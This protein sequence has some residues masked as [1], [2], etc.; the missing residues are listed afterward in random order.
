MIGALMARARATKSRIPRIAVERLGLPPSWL[1]Y[2][3][4]QRETLAECAART[5]LDDRLHVVHPAGVHPAPLP[6]DVARRDA[7]PDDRGW[8]G[9]SFRDVPARENDPTLIATLPDCTIAHDRLPP[10]HRFGGDYYVGILNADQRSLELREIRFRPMHAEVLNAGPRV[11]RIDRATLVTERVYHNYSHWLTAHLPKLVLLRERGE[12]NNVILPP[13]LPENHRAS[14]RMLGIEPDDFRVFDPAAVQ[15][16]R[17]LT[18]L[19]TD[20]F[21]PELVRSVR[22]RIM[23]ATSTA[24]ATPTASPT[25]TAGATGTAASSPTA[26]V[27]P[28]AATPRRRIYISRAGALRRR[29][30]NEED[31]WPSFAA[32]GFERVRMEDLPFEAQVELMMDTGVLAAP[33][34]AGLTNMIFCAPGTHVVEI[35]DLG[36]PNPNFYAL[37]S[38]LGHP[39]WLVPAD[40]EG[41]GH[42]LTHDLR[43]DPARIDGLLQALEA[44]GD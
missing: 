10:D 11:E 30:L 32:H 16:V 37:A 38:A 17:E 5:G 19:S 41:D 2:R 1:S 8:W 28:A 20:R 35:A 3:Y 44:N 23:E 15:R 27:R 43:V 22:E 25:S 18:L 9:F 39:Y 26:G 12:L 34:G 31:I 24:G 40:A 4:L 13:S 36:F 21:R 42:P 7:L 33:H 14:L 6:R 29:L